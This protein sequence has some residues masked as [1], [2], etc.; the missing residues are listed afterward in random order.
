MRTGSHIAMTPLYAYA[1]RGQRAMGKVPRN[2][3]AN[4][5]LLASLSVQG[6]G[7]ALILDGAADAAAELVGFF[8]FSGRF[9]PRFR[10][11]VALVRGE[12]G[13]WTWGALGILPTPKRPIS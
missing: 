2:Y 8:F 1:P 7:E 11:V 9:R 5:T 10:I 6:M 4:M 3:G 12:P 13:R